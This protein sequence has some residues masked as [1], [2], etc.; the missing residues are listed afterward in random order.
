MTRL[1]ECA[2]ES[3]F[4]CE[5]NQFSQ[6]SAMA[7]ILLG[8]AHS[9][10]GEHDRATELART[11]ID[12][13]ESLHSYIA[14]PWFCSMAAEIFLAA[15]RLQEARKLALKGID[16]ANRGGER[17]MESEN[18]R[19]LA[20]IL[21]QIPNHAHEEIQSHMDNALVMARQ[22]K[23]RSLELRVITSITKLASEPDDR[24]DGLKLLSS[25]YDSFAEGLDTFVLKLAR[26]YL[27]SS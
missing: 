18:H 3:L 10:D 9:Y 17:F 21:V 6:W 13:K 19:L 25:I 15:G 11:G 16:Y 23:A 24:R 22:Q 4:L 26:S 14:M 12:E 5:Q 8:Y 20:V 2:Q 7:K 1:V 27:D